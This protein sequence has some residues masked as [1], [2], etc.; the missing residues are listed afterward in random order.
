MVQLQLELVVG[1]NVAYLPMLMVSLIV[2]IAQSIKS[3]SRA[4]IAHGFNFDRIKA[5]DRLSEPET[6]RSVLGFLRCRSPLLSSLY[7]S[8]TAVGKHPAGVFTSNRSQS[9]SFEPSLLISASTPIESSCRNQSPC[10]RVARRR[11]LSRWL[12]SWKNFKCHMLSK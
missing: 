9:D 4:V 12:L 7:R 8:Y 2:S 10:T 5:I 6:R 1:D 11:T 3:T